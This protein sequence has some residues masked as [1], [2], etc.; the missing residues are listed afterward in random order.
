MYVYVRFK[1]SAFPSLRVHFRQMNFNYDRI[2]NL[3]SVTGIKQRATKEKIPLWYD[4]SVSF[5]K[6]VTETNSKRE[7]E[8][9]FLL[10]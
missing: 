9:H 5:R 1:I 7:R 6:R 10:Q 8:K 4:E 2:N 3:N